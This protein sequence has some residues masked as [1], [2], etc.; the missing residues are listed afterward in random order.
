MAFH[1]IERYLKWILIHIHHQQLAKHGGRR[2]S[3]FIAII[4]TLMIK[5][6]EMKQSY[7]VYAF[8]FLN[9]IKN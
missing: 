2:K 7:F 1:G 4:F 5:Y 9:L 8:W 3:N 6:F